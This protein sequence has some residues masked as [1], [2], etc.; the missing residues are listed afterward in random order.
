MM[1]DETLAEIESRCQRQYVEGMD[2]ASKL[3]LTDF[4]PFLGLGH[5][6]ERTRFYFQDK[7]PLASLLL[8]NPSILDRPTPEWEERGLDIIR[9]R[10]GT[11]IGY[12]ELL[13]SSAA[14]YGLWYLLNS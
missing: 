14:I 3:R 8:N 4:I 7:K 9:K 13:S 12:N 10:K 11:L 1:E 6:I 5:F 2:K